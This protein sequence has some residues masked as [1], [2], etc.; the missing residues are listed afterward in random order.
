MMAATFSSRRKHAAGFTLTELM[1]VVVIVGI[2]AAIAYPSYQNQVIRSRR[3]DGQAALM[4]LAQAQERYM[5]RCGEYATSIAGDSDC[6]AEGLGR[7]TDS[8]EGYY[9]L[10]L[11][12][13]TTTR[14]TLTADAVS[15]QDIDTECD[16]LTLSSTGVRDTTGTGDDCW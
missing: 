9:R 15:P 13:S 3:A 7:S 6:D 1:I 2:L 16:A 8:P 12:D 5:A 11:S 10:S 4:S 14:F